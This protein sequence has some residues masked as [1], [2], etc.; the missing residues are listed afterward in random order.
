MGRLRDARWPF[1]PS[2]SA[3]GRVAA[4][5]S[6]LTDAACACAYDSIGLS[7][8]NYGFIGLAEMEDNTANSFINKQQKHTSDCKNSINNSNPSILDINC[9]HAF[10]VLIPD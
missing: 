9:F 5:R 4:A 1:P 6:R 7:T 10:C 8:S 3:D 2:V